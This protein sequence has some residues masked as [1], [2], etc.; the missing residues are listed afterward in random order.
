MNGEA[1]YETRPWKYQNDTINSDVW[2]TSKKDAV[3]AIL[4]K[5]PEDPTKIVLGAVES[6]EATNVTLLGCDIK[7]QWV[8]EPSGSGIIIDISEVDMNSLSTTWALAFKIVNI[9]ANKKIKYN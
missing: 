1:I 9:N 7:I 3:Y 5:Y 2:Y 8:P 4:L 6:T